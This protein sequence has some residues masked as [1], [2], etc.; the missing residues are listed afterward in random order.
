MADRLPEYEVADKSGSTDTFVG[1]ATT[2]FVAVPA[3]AAGDI[4]EFSVECDEDQDLQRTL[5]VSLDGGTTTFAKLYPTGHVSGII[6]DVKTQ[7][8]IKGSVNGVAY[9]IVLSREPV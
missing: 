8:H 1:T 7:I 6:K 9:T 3:V 2:S 5:E 4:Q